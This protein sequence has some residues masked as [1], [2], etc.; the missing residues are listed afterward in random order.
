MAWCLTWSDNCGLHA[1]NAY[2]LMRGYD[3]AIDWQIDSNPGHA[4]RL[5]GTNQFCTSDSCDGFEYIVCD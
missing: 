4:T 2:C 1:A 5:I 3:H